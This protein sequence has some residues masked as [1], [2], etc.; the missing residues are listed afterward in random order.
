M[1]EWLGEEESTRKIEDAIIKV[2]LE[3]KNLTPDLGGSFRTEDVVKAIS[4]K[5]ASM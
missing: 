2:L 4:T 5:L 3:G 1:L